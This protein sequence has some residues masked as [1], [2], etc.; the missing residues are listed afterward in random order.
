MK[1]MTTFAF[2]KLVIVMGLTAGAIVPLPALAQQA[3]TEGAQKP[4]GQTA[5]QSASEAID[6]AKIATNEA[7]EAAKQAFLEAIN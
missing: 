7:I 4:N 2:I 6:K 3:A 1:R 5:D